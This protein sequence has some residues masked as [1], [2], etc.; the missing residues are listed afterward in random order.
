MNLLT[1][2]YTYSW[3]ACSD[4]ATA[5][6]TDRRRCTTAA[7]SSAGADGPPASLPPR[8]AHCSH[9]AQQPSQPQ[10]GGSAE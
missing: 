8:P 3:C 2:A 6:H 1:A 5:T 7:A 9:G 4:Q 10:P